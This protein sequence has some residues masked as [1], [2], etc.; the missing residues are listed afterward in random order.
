MVL[1]EVGAQWKVEN[2]MMN[3]TMNSVNSMICDAG[4]LEDDVPPP[5]PTRMPMYSPSPMM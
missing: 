2:W 1:Q 5:S 3:W 4:E